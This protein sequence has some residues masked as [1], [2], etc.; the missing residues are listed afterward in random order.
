MERENHGERKPREKTKRENQREN[1]EKKAY[2]RKQKNLGVARIIRSNKPVRRP[3]LI[4]HR[5]THELA[6]V[7]LIDL[8]KRI[9]TLNAHR[10]LDVVHWVGLGAWQ[11]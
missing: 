9:P 2:V 11:A 5:A 10:H 6:A 3:K 7:I 8:I 4:K 1:Q